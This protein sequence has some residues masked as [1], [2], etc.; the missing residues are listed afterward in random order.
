MVHT[1]VNFSDGRKM[2]IANTTEQ[3]KVHLAATGVCVR[4]GGRGG[5]PAVAHT[6][7]CCCRC[8]W[9][10]ASALRPC[11][12]PHHPRA[13]PRITPVPAPPPPTPWRAGGKVVTRFPPEPNGYLHIGHAKAMFV[14]FGMAVQYDGVCYLRYDDTNPEVRRGGGGGRGGWGGLHVRRAGVRGSGA[15]PPRP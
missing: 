6:C 5:P 14:D 2:G 10:G 1:T 9:P 7:C 3:L 11:L 4:G 12:A 15:S 13:S 8:C